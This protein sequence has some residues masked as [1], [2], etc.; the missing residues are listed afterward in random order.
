MPSI[1]ITIN[2]TVLHNNKCGQ[3]TIGYSSP[4][5]RN[6][7]PPMP[8]IKSIASFNNG[9][10]LE[11]TYKSLS[12][13]KMSVSNKKLSHADS[14]KTF[15][16]ANEIEAEVLDINVY[17]EFQGKEKIE[18]KKHSVTHVKSNTQKCETMRK[19]RIYLKECAEKVRSTLA[20]L[21]SRKPRRTATAINIS[22]FSRAYSRTST[23]SHKEG[24]NPSLR[25]SVKTSRIKQERRKR[26][27]T[28]PHEASNKFIGLTFEALGRLAL[29][30]IIK[31]QIKV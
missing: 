22:T 4:K 12:L 26:R 19:A 7:F 6:Y 1:T 21:A 9:N 14:K 18:E 23:P 30:P 3:T 8:A 2:T 25:D 27:F 29:E 15:G 28:T 5:P 13:S 24:N 17:P 31:E 11:V 20:G 10:K 16:F